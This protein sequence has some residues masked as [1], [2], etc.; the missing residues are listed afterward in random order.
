[1]GFFDAQLAK[2]LND[3]G[4]PF[5]QIIGMRVNVQFIRL[6]NCFGREKL[7]ALGLQQDP[8][9]DA[10]EL[11]D[12]V[13]VAR[14]GFVRD[15]ATI[16]VNRGDALKEPEFCQVRQQLP[17]QIPPPLIVHKSGFDFRQKTFVIA[18]WK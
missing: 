16:Q 2:D 11:H 4:F 14:L 13:Y 7:W 9:N 6:P 8:G 17:P 10:I 3:V 15:E 12:Q 18:R 1:L 5:P